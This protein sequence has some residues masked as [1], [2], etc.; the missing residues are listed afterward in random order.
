M[1]RFSGASISPSVFDGLIVQHIAAQNDLRISIF[2]IVLPVCTYG[3]VPLLPVYGKQ[4]HNALLLLIK[5]IIQ[6]EAEL[7]NS[8]QPDHG[9]LIL[10]VDL[11]TVLQLKVI[12]C[13][14]K[15]QPYKSEQELQVT[16]AIAEHEG[17]P[18][19][20]RAF[21]RD[22]RI[23]R[24]K[25]EIASDAVRARVL[26]LKIQDRTQRIASVGR[27]G[28]RETRPR[29]KLTLISPTGPPEAP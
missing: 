21:Q 6:V 29:T 26:H 14:Q 24:P 12:I 15:W 22:A 23:V 9:E 8:C 17:M 27:K 18:L 10:I 13:G 5:I 25:R 20:Y 11:P 2:P 28:T 3:V 19:G 16:S 4:L 1:S 7:V